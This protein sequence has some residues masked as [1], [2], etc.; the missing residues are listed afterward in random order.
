MLGNK[1]GGWKE[2]QRRERKGHRIGYIGDVPKERGRVEKRGERK[3]A[4]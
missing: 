3:V 1:G 4:G 2:E